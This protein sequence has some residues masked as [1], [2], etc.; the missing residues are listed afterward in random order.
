MKIAIAL[1][2]LTLVLG[3]CS[4]GLPETKPAPKALPYAPPP[5]A[6][7]D[8]G[9]AC[10]A[11]VRLCADGSTVSRTGMACAFA[12]CPGATPK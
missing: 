3:A 12:A 7:L 11:D 1:L 2:A 8:E 9:A 4:T 6:L 10:A 5:P